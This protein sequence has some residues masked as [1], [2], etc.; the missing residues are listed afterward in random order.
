VAEIW[1]DIG[2]EVYR[3]ETGG[4]GIITDEIGVMVGGVNSDGCS[5]SRFLHHG[6]ELGSQRA[7]ER[8]RKGRW[9]EDVEEGSSSQRIENKPAQCP[10]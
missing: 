5:W 6:Y 1:T 3:C 8:R 4:R 9:R 2:N 7:N 10:Q